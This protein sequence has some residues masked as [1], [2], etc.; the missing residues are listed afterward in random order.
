[1]DEETTL[2][3]LRVNAPLNLRSESDHYD[4]GYVFPRAPIDARRGNETMG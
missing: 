2:R 4:T 3:Q 1:M